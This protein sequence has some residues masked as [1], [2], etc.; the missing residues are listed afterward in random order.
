MCKR[1]SFKKKKEVRFSNINSFYI[2]NRFFKI[3]NILH[4]NKEYLVMVIHA[5]YLTA[6]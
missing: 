1:D 5:D 4:R 2:M 3:I 6:G